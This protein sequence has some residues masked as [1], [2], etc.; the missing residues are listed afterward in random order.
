MPVDV[1]VELYRSD[2]VYK[3]QTAMLANTTMT[4]MSNLAENVYAT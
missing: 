4:T 3:S 2:L 1:S